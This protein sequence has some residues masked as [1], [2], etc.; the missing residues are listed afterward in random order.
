[1]SSLCGQYPDG[2]ILLTTLKDGYPYWPIS[3][4]VGGFG[5]KPNEN[6]IFLSRIPEEDVGLLLK[7]ITKSSSIVRIGN[8]EGA[9]VELVP[10]WQKYCEK[11]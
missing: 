1:M 4:Y 3:C 11:L 6:C 5:I 2:S 8:I 10:D 7:R 9:L